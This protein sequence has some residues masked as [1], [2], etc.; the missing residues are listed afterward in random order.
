MKAVASET[1]TVSSTSLGFTEA[2]LEDKRGS[3]DEIRK[4]IFVVEDDGIRFT[5]DGSIPTASVGT[6]AYVDDVVEIDASDIES[7]R[8][9]RQTTDA[10]IFVTYF[11]NG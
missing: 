4:A 8:A 3:I 6:P 9:I 11:S 7:F 1:I 10:S 2:T 5:L